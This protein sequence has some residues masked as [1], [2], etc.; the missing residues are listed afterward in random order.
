MAKYEVTYELW[1]TVY[2]WAVLNGY[3]IENAGQEGN[4]GVI[5]EDLSTSKHMPV[6]V[7]NWHDAMVW[8]NAY[9]EMEELTPVYTNANGLTITDST[10]ANA[11]ECNNAGVNWSANGYRLPT[12][13]EWQ[14]AASYQDGTSWTPFNHASGANAA[15]TNQ[16]ATELVANYGESA[17]NR[18]QEVGSLHANLLGI[19]DMSGNVWEWC[20]DWYSPLPSTPQTDYRGG[21]S[22][23]ER[24]MRG[25]SWG[26]TAQVQQV[27]ARGKYWVSIGKDYIGLRLVQTP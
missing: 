12:E 26:A 25:G 4:E 19:H 27:G 16:A 18:T 22:G 24:V 13:G 20:W 3:T 9:S 6:T 21:A 11:V 7:I 15:F 1:F 14:Y 5:G 10:S 2:N 23:T 17:P 8:C